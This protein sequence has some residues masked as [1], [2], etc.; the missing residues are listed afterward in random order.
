MYSLI[1]GTA[2]T[3]PTEDLR[4][5]LQEVRKDLLDLGLRNPLLNY[6]LL[7]S[8][9]L[10]TAGTSASEVFQSLVTE[11]HELEFL[12]AHGVVPRKQLLLAEGEEDSSLRERAWREL[13]AEQ[14]ALWGIGDIPEGSLVA[15][16]GEKE[17][18][19]RLLATF[20]AARTSIE[21][22]GVNT[23][24][25]ALGMLSWH[26]PAT[27][28]EVHRAP[29]LLVPVELTR[30]SAAEG[31]R[32]RYSG[33]D[34]SP[35]LCLIEFLKQFGIALDSSN[36]GE[37]FDVERYL[38]RFTSAISANPTWSI[39][40]QSV[41][42][43][44]FSFSKFLMYRD[45]D[46]DTWPD[47]DALLNNDLLG[48]LLGAN[49]FYGDGSGLTDSSFLDDYLSTK[50]C[51]HVVDADSTQTLALLDVASGT[52]MVIQ[53]PPGTG[54]SQTIINLIA[55]AL[56]N[57]KKVLFVSEKQ[58]ALDVVKKRLDKI[59][60]GNPC[61]ELHSNKAKKKE[62]INE[63]KRTAGLE[64]FSVLP[65][66]ADRAALSATRD[67]LNRYCHAVNEPIGASGER[68][69]DLFGQIL[70]VIAR[71]ADVDN[72]L[73]D[74]PES[75]NWNEIETLRT[76]NLVKALQ[77]RLDA[78]GI[79]IQYPFWG[80]NIRVILPATRDRLRHDCKEAADATGAL[81]RDGLALASLLGSEL[82]SCSADFSKLRAIALRLLEAPPLKGLDL[83][84]EAWAKQQS[85]ILTTIAAGRQLRDIR[86]EWTARLRPEA[87]ITDVNS[88]RNEIQMLGGQWWR[89]MSPS[90]RSAVRLVKSLL[91]EPHSRSAQDYLAITNAI[92][93]AHVC[94]EKLAEFDS[95]F[96]EAY[97][98]YRSEER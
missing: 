24:F 55:E 9:G 18:E 90:W 80:S 92:E 77:G 43:G 97:R 6:R 26:D 45:L 71:L 14:Q 47:A 84:G 13:P 73:I 70:P 60:L 89:F 11:G 46:P 44:F 51:F 75:I 63:L 72:P 48:K 66:P 42:L 8:R 86:E 12:S 74:L 64:L 58:A 95:L 93:G 68:P 4:P 34:V 94:Q 96:R 85:V 3:P 67:D 16:H 10:E 19:S 29:I 52:N 53:G 25:V 98:T 61:L 38:D 41:V 37:D 59:G 69:I 27:P 56:A 30:Q 81:K 62:V 82:P 7:K 78:V 15:V 22:Q 1:M 39:D 36:D 33:D 49:S 57:K 79:P 83:H 17:L 50:E 65:R 54:K 31:F 88:L 76:R 21:E 5:I 28:E 23:L 91:T 32:L 35:N 87:W 20:Y 2:T 40:R